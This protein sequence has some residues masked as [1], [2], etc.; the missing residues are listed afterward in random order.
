MPAFVAKLKGTAG[1]GRWMSEAAKRNTVALL[2][3]VGLGA[4]IALW[5][6]PWQMERLKEAQDQ[7]NRQATASQE[8]AQTKLV[9]ILEKSVIATERSTAASDRSTAATEAQTKRIDS[10]TERMDDL[11][12]SHTDLCEKLDALIDVQTKA[13]GK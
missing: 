2:S 4:V 7:N 5:V 11:C 3:T 6:I 9:E 13:A 8:F 12:N 1:K 10:Q